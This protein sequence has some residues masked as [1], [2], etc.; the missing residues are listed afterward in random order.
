MLPKEDGRWEDSVQDTG[1]DE[2]LTVAKAAERLEITKEAVR[3]R[4]H[5]GTL[6]SDKDADGTVRV[7]VPVSGTASGTASSTDRDELVSELR[8]LVADLREQLEAERRANEENRR[9]LLLWSSGCRSWKLPRSRLTAA[10][11]PARFQMRQSRESRGPL[12]E[13]LRRMLRA[14][15][16]RGCSENKS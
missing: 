12:P 11:A 5:R 13:T 4:I 8:N 14:P 15:G 6:R 9:C 2:R 7:Y 3:K 16:G 10:R 1:M